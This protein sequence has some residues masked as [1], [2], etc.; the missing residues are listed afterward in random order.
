MREILFK[1]KQADT[2]EWV[3]GYLIS[4]YHI[5]ANSG[6]YDCTPE[7]IGQ[8]GLTDK[9]GVKIFE[10]DI[11]KMSR[12]NGELEARGVVF[13]DNGCFKCNAGFVV[14]STNIL[15]S[16]DSSVLELIGNIHDNPELLGGE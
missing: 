13:F 10:G 11:I 8:Y 15:C 5:Y 6:V 1:G 2:G 4:Y 3:Y 12:Y 14:G 16:F 9:N 7:T